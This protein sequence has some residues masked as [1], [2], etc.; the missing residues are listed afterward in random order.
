[1]PQSASRVEHANITVSNAARSAAV[2][3]QIFQWSIRWEGPAMLGGYTIHL[4]SNDSYI[5]LY[6]RRDH[7]VD[8]DYLWEKGLPLNHTGV[9]V[10]DI[11]DVESRV[12]AAGLLPFNHGDYAP[13]KRFYF[14]DPDGIEFEVISYA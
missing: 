3:G 8:I 6:Q 13:G 5:A 14:L 11:T 4:G 12:V 7:W 9:V 1:M 2:L 10:D